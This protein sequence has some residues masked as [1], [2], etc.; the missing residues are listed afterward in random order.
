MA[1]QP[2]YAKIIQWVF[3]QHYKPGLEEFSFLREELVLAAK[4]LELQTPRN[5]GDIP[6]QFRYRK[7][8]PDAIIQTA[9]PDHHWVL[10][11]DGDAKYKFK[12]WRLAFI[13]PN[14]GLIPT[15]IP[16]STPAAVRMYALN[17]EQALLAILRYNRLIDL[18][19]RQNCFHLQSH[20]RTN[21]VNVGQIEIDDI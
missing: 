12:Q 6:Y 21:V 5:L 8:L 18:F 2:V 7:A 1:E 10:L 9:S 16:D 14:K 17:D 13:E 4:A 15:K 3:D 20:L 19:L 11:P